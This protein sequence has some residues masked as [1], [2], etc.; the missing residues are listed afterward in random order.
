MSGY[1][2]ISKSDGSRRTRPTIVERAPS[3]IR[4]DNGDSQHDQH[5]GLWRSFLILA[6]IF[7]AIAIPAR[8]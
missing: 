6:A 3:G 8:T 2:E 7:V 4:H 5:G 1:I